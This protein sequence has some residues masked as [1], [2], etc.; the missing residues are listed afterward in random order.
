MSATVPTLSVNEDKMHAFLG[1]VFGDFG[2]SLSAALV[3]I[4]QKLG[5]YKA[6][7]KAGPVTPAELAQR[8]DTNEL[9]QFR[10]ATE[11]LLVA[12]LKRDVRLATRPDRILV[13]EKKRFSAVCGEDC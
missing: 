12:S 9:K 6:I 7:S 11:T 4:G 10:R 3:Y 1:K 13:I 8:T 5:S 2:A